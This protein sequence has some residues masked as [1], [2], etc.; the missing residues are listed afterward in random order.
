MRDK[1]KIPIFTTG[2]Q[3][4]S[5]SWKGGYKESSEGG[6]QPPSVGSERGNV[7]VPVGALV[8]FIGREW[9][10]TFGDGDSDAAMV[11]D[12]KMVHRNI[13]AGHQ[14]N[15]D[16]WPDYISMLLILW[17]QEPGFYADD[18]WKPRAWFERDGDWES[19]NGW[20]SGRGPAWYM[21][22]NQYGKGKSLW[23]VIE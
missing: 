14:A 18:R 21:E 3:S 4:S 2:P 9:R 17:L 22:C 16:V 1:R 19:R 23:E 6:T 13:I 11:L 8:R 10:V 20:E 5:T 12:R 15:P 7:E